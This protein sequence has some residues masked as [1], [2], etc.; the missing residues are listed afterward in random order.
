MATITVNVDDDL[1]ERMDRHPESTG[2]GSRDR[3]SKRKSR[4][5]K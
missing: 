5:S 3:P 2:V 1:K 4:R